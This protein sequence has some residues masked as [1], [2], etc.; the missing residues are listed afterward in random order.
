MGRIMNDFNDKFPIKD[1]KKLTFSL[2][3]EE[4]YR[5]TTLDT[6]AQQGKLAEIMLNNLLNQTCLPR[7]G[8]KGSPDVGIEYDLASGNFY[9]YVPRLLCDMCHARKAVYS[10]PAEGDKKQ[11]LCENCMKI[12]DASKKAVNP[13]V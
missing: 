11:N 6:I 10:I 3:K 2:S 12:V 4:Q 1:Y 9:A 8:V 7:V 5:L 13:K